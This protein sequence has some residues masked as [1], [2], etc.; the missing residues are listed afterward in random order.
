MNRSRSILMFLAVALGTTLSFSSGR[1]V[2]QS[3]SVLAEVYGRGVH[4]FY[5]GDYISAYDLLSSAIDAGSRD[6]RAYYF[7]GIV[8]YVQGRTEEAEA[9]WAQGAAMEASTGG[10]YGVGRALSR[11][12]GSGRLK[13]EQIRQQARLDA[14]SQA[15]KRSDQRLRELGV[16]PQ[17]GS[18]APNSAEPPAGQAAPAAAAT[19]APAAPETPVPA[20]PF[21]DDGNALAEGEPKVESDNALEGLDG[22]P[23]KDDAAAANA[24]GGEAMNAD[25]GGNA[26]PFGGNAEPAAG[27]D[28]FGGAPAGNDGGADPFGGNG[29][30]DPFGGAPAGDDPFGGDPFGN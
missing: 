11:F 4:A 8:S 9:D 21:E 16:T 24:A 28:P 15:A 1:A 17:A 20:N 14:M 25:A 19:P 27:A 12:Q 10:A 5:A 3:P 13:L 6:P 2:G 30:N 7:R 22:N 23:F 26:D 18:S 29:G